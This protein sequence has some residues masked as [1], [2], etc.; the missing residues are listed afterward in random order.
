MTDILKYSDVLGVA[1]ELGVSEVLRDI[2]M[3]LLDE[4][5]GV[6][7]TVGVIDAEWDCDKLKLGDIG[8]VVLGVERILELIDA[9]DVSDCIVEGVGIIEMLTD[10]LIVGEAET[11]GVILMVDTMLVLGSTGA[12][13][14]IAA[15]GLS[16]SS[17]T[18]RSL[19]A[20]PSQNRSYEH[21]LNRSSQRSP[22][23]RLRTHRRR[24]NCSTHRH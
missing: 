18:Q 5:F 16:S 2:K 23:I 11:I 20:C 15:D 7:E 1:D 22:F 6:S 19:P 4:A 24:R 9:V 8:G 10:T 14:A 17:E 12:I 21:W 13:G 3:L